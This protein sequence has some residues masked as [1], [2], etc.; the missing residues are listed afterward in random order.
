MDVESLVRPHI[1]QLQPYVPPDLETIAARA[2]LAIDQL[3]RLDSNENAFGPSPRVAQALARYSGYQFYPD[4]RA[5]REAVARY[6]GVTPQQVVLGNGA[7]ELINLIIRL[8]LAPDD[9]VVICPPTF[10]MYRFYTALDCH[11]LLTVPRDDD[12][13]LDMAGIEALVREPNNAVRPRL[14]FLPSPGNPDGQ[15]IPLD[16]VRRLLALPLVVVMDEAYIE[17]GG[18]TAL[19]LLAEHGNLI[20]VRTFSKWAGMA[21]LRL[22]YAL[23]VPELA[24]YLERVRDPYNVNAAAVVAALATFDDLETVRANVAHLIAERERLQRELAA[25]GWLEPLPS[26]A[27]FILCRVQG[28]SGPELADALAERG[29]LIRA[30]PTPRLQSYVRI[31][32]GRPEQNDALLRALREL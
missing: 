5:L 12:F 22:G 3:I 21:G 27:N 14:I 20:V 8:L 7:D 26:Q 11:P 30:F 13:A 15:A 10:P 25:I 16:V 28:C 4:Y 17:F 1:H 31:T 32:V 2:G 19:P 29:I 9:A 18:E 23:L 6:A 24:G